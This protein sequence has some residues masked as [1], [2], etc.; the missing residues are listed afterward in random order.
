[1]VA[2]AKICSRLGQGLEEEFWPATLH[3]RFSNAANIRTPMGLI[4]ILAFWK[5]LQPYALVLKEPW[6]FRELGQ[7]ELKLSRLGLW[8]DGEVI[9]SFLGARP[10]DLKRPKKFLPAAGADEMLRQF[11][12]SQREKG[13]VSLIFRDGGDNLYTHFLEPRIRSFREAMRKRDVKDSVRLAAQTAGCGPGLT[14]SSDDFLCGYLACLPESFWEQVA[15][16]ASKAAAQKTNDISAA[17]LIKAGEGYFSEDILE[18]M[19]H[20]SKNACGEEAK[21]AVQKTAE[22]GSSSGCDF[23]TGMYFGIL[24]FYENGGIK[25]EKVRSS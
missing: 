20:L 22:F 3:S 24:D 18:L 8:Q 4:S 11:L 6:D 19:K 1:M 12:F 15:L 2:C 13:I 16:P 7:G 17:L 14:P 9:I 23:L 5:C 10:I 25:S 21:A